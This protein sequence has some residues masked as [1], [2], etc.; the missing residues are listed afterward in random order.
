MFQISPVW[1]LSIFA[2]LHHCNAQKGALDLVPTTT[3]VPTGSPSLILEPQQS[4][5]LDV[6]YADPKDNPFRTNLLPGPVASAVISAS[7]VTEEVGESCVEPG[8]NLN[9]TWADLL[10]E[11]LFPNGT[12]QKVGFP[13]DILPFLDEK[14]NGS[15]VSEITRGRLFEYC[16]PKNKKICY[17]APKRNETAD[18]YKRTVFSPDERQ[19]VLDTRFYP[20][21]TIGF[22]GNQ[23]CTGTLIGPRHVLTAGHCV[24]TGKGGGWINNLDFT[25]VKRPGAGGPTNDVAFKWEEVWSVEGWTKKSKIEYDYAL[26]ILAT[27]DTGEGWL[28]F[29]YHSGINDNWSMNLVGYP[30]D[31]PSKTMWR[32]FG[33]VIDASSLLLLHRID[34]F[35]CQSGSPFYL[36]ERSPESRVIYGVHGGT[37]TKTSPN[38]PDF[39]NTHSTT[40]NRAARIDKQRFKQICGWMRSSLC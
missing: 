35:E 10:Q 31:K 34:T 21:N 40:W 8:Q 32:G 13:L 27:Q 19:E 14:L 25:L 17:P 24:H 12:A 26:I 33:A 3:L 7:N 2:I 36:Y 9:Q 18:R 29:G 11:R 38:F 28:P 5:A 15:V 1:L 6:I 37:I 23:Q 20:F 4:L 22:I 30:C 39:W 16:D